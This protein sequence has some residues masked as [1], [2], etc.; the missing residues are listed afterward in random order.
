MSSRAKWPEYGN[1]ICLLVDYGFDLFLA[2]LPSMML[3]NN[4]IWNL[5]SKCFVFIL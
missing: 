4:S 2:K 1:F 5:E 3:I